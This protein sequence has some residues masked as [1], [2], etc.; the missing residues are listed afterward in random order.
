[1]FDCSR[2]LQVGQVSVP[3]LFACFARVV[4]LVWKSC[5][6]VPKI[7]GKYIHG[8]ETIFSQFPADLVQV[9]S[10]Y[11]HQVCQIIVA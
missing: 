2:E 3:V 4:T 8:E 9:F 5:H 6:S 10:I 1:M 11:L 7:A